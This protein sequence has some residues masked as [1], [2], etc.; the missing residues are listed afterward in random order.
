MISTSI[1]TNTLPTLKE[2]DSGLSVKLLQKLLIEIY[3]YD[4]VV[5]D[6]YFGNPT[7]QAVQ[8]FQREY[9]HTVE[10]KLPEPSYND[11]GMVNQITWQALA[12]NISC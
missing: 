7:K 3:D 9:D 1:D 4:Y 6:A 5:Y 12:E 2:G 11:Y 10:Y 8:Q